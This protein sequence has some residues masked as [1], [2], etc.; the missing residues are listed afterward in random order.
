M[1]KNRIGLT[2]VVNQ[3][4]TIFNW[5][6][7]EW[8]IICLC[9][10]FPFAEKWLWAAKFVIDTFDDISS[11]HIYFTGLSPIANNVSVVVVVRRDGDQCRRCFCAIREKMES[12]IVCMSMYSIEWTMN[13]G[14]MSNTTVYNGNTI[15]LG[16]KCHWIVCVRPCGY[17]WMCNVPPAPSPPTAI[18]YRIFLVQFVG[19]HRR[20]INNNRRRNTHTHTQ[21][22]R[23]SNVNVWNDVIVWRW[24][25]SGTSYRHAWAEACVYRS[26]I[27]IFPICAL[28]SQ[29]FE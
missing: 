25:F 1:L 23:P 20:K 21:F 7:L 13:D 29:S 11:T 12:M 26:E 15:K 3:R 17:G 8:R 19:C 9:N 10:N 18:F 5:W 14:G 6:F 4:N 27:F 2:A 28:F 24:L 16:Y 22:S